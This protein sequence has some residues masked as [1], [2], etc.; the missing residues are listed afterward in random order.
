MNLS[1]TAWLVVND[2]GVSGVGVKPNEVTMSRNVCDG[3]A[4][5]IANIPGGGV[6]AGAREH[7]RHIG[8]IAYVPTTNIR[9]DKSTRYVTRTGAV[10][11]PRHISYIA[12][13]PVT[14]ISNTPG[15]STVA[16][17]G[18]HLGHVGYIAHVPIAN[19]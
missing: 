12:Y 18:E 7:L 1:P 17:V 19:V 5:D 15:A 4:A 3:P 11:H 9:N 10:K 14:E 8:Y 13:I 16:G 6:V 2:R